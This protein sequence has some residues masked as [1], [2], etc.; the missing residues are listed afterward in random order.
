MPRLLVIGGNAAGMSAASKAARSSPAMEIAVF[1]AGGDFS[2][3]ACGLPYV[4][5]REASGFDGLRALSPGEIGSRGIEARPYARAMELVAGRKRVVFRDEKSGKTFEESY[6]SLLIATG[7]LPFIPDIAGF[8]GDNMFLL[9]TLDDGK[10]LAGFINRE[11][12]RSA[13]ILGSGY[14]AMEMAESLTKAGIQVT[15]LAR[16][17]RLLGKLNGKFRDRLAMELEEN[18]V[19]LVTHCAVASADRDGDTVRSLATSRGC[20]RADFFLCATGVRPATG[21][22]SGS[23][24]SLGVKGGIETDGMCRTSA[25]SV[26]AAGDCC[27][28]R[29]M[30]TGKIVYAPLGTTANRMGRIAGANI[31]G[32]REEFPGIIG[33]SIARVFGLEAAVTG[34]SAED[35]AKEGFDAVEVSVKGRTRPSYYTGGSET[36]VSLVSDRAGRILGGQVMGGEGVKGRIDTIAAAILGGLKAGDLVHLDMAYAPPFSTVTDPLLTCSSELRK[37]LGQN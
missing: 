3:G 26:W 31:A 23:Q 19:R 16:T 1:D 24:V 13:C 8:S 28:V 36:S 9:H 21:F 11:R 12:P 20:I 17:E 30:V 29:H 7:S 35:S 25:P 2:W 4:F 34:L 27:C 5:S 32:G 22:L 33:T 37:K 15:V 14:I 18:G 6:D 10:R